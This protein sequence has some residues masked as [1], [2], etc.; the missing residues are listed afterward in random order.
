MKVAI[1]VGSENDLEI[2]NE[3]CETLE[4]FGVG[5]YIS[6]TS[7]HRT[8]EKVKHFLEKA[9]KEGCEVIIAAAGMSAHLAGVMA[10]HTIKPV[11]AVPIATGALNGVDAL[12]SMSQMP[13]GIPVA[14]VT[15]GKAGAKNAAI[16]SVQILALKYPELKEKLNRYKIELAEN[17]VKKDN[18]LQEKGIKKFLEDNKKTK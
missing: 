15:I 16:L 17:I 14:T 18:E 11:I 12:Y 13:G 1:V 2:L 4:K 7:A 8:P 3:A 9:E 10:A 5:Y 6:I